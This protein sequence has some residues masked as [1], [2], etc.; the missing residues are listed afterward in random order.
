MNIGGILKM[1]YNVKIIEVGSNVNDML[2]TGL[3][4]LFNK[5]APGDLRPF[6]VITEENKQDGQL[7]VGDV[8]TIVDIAYT[9]TSIGEV[10]NENLYSLGHVTLCFDGAVEAKLP[11][12]IHL[13]PD[14]ES[15]LSQS[16]KIT[17]K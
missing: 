10:V 11:G 16:G 7:D 9:I 8:V 12:H 14:F 1:K 6:C 4:I 5:N 13:T 17:I 2:Q 15:D 3:L